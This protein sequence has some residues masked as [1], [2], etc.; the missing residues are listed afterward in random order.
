MA[1]NKSS[2]L[3][4]GIIL[5]AIAGAIAGLFLAP[6]A[7]EQLRSDAKKLSKN[8]M[9]KAQKIQKEIEDKEPDE[10]LRIIFGKVSDESRELFGKA[11]AE[12]ALGLAQLRGNY[13]KI[14]KTKYKKIVTEAVQTVK[15][16]NRVPD[17]ELTKL[18]HYLEGD[19][20]KLAA[21][22]KSPVKKTAARKKAN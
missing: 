7:G 10:A 9:K 20:K 21:P 16:K 8:V 3:G 11:Q 15:D 22:K 5:G 12:V 17:E 18:L 6:K 14:S 1:N 4:F 2:K 19:F 13:K